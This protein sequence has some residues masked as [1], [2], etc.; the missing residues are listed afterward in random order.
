MAELTRKPPSAWSLNETSHFR[1]QPSI[2]RMTGSPVGEGAIESSRADC[3]ACAKIPIPWDVK[4]SARGT[5]AVS[6]EMAICLGSARST[7]SGLPI[8]PGRIG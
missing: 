4:L 8:R 7:R 6:G 3:T 2:K 5:R 1:G